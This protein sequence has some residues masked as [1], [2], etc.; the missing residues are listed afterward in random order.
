MR[1]R[2]RPETLFR[3]KLDHIEGD[4]LRRLYHITKVLN[5]PEIVRM[6]PHSP[7]LRCV[8]SS[9]EHFINECPH[10]PHA[11]TVSRPT[12]PMTEA[13]LCCSVWPR[14]AASSCRLYCL[15]HHLK[16]NLCVSRE[17]SLLSH[18]ASEGRS[19]HTCNGREHETAR[20]WRAH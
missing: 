20:R 6:G 8:H 7:P 16:G 18:S 12:Q 3:L 1:R 4:E 2:F 11:Q 14:A 19:A 9:G 5:T 17:T 15:H 10:D 13:I